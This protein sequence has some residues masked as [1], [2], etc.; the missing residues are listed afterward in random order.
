MPK[1]EN[2]IEATPAPPKTLTE[3]VEEIHGIVVKAKGDGVSPV[4]LLVGVTGRLGLNAL[5]FFLTNFDP[6]PKKAAGK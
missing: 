6:G 1:N 4:Q 2:A 3:Y 5:D